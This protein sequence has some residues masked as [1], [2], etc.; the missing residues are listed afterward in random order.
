ME[1]HRARSGRTARRALGLALRATLLGALALAPSVVPEVAQADGTAD[2]ADL[3]F[4]LGN[5]A[6]RAGNFLEALE[7]YLASNRLVPNQNVVFNIARAYQRLA[8]YPE[9]YRYYAT[10]LATETD[11]EARTRITAALTELATQ[12]ALID[13]ESAPA[14]AT[15]FVDRIDLGSIGTAPLTIALPAGTYR[16]ITRLP[17]HHD[18]TSE[19]LSV[20]V[21]Q[22]SS[23]RLAL[24]RVVGTLVVRGHEGAELRVDTEDGDAACTL[25]CSLPVAPGP[26]VIHVRAA[27]HQPLA[28]AVAVTEAE[29]TRASITLVAETGSVVVRADVE[30]ALVQIDSVAVG[31]TP[32]VAAGI[33]V[34]TR[35]VRVSARGYEPEEANVE[36]TR[37]RQVE[38]TS[39]R[40]RTLHEVSAASREVETIEDAPASVSVISTA[41]LEAF[42]YPTLVEALRGQR[43]FALTSDSTY[44]NAGVRGIGQPNDY[45]SRLRVLQDGA[46][47]NENILQQAFIGYDGRVDLGDVERIEIVRGAGSVLYG[48][49]AVSGVINLVPLSHELPTSARFD[50]SLADGNVGRARGAFNVHLSDK[51]GVRGSV[52]VARSGGR[53]EVLYFDLDGDGTVDAN[54][55]DGVEQFQAVTGSVRAWAGPLVVQG[56]FTA[57]TVAIPTGTFDTIYNRLE[58]NFDDHL[59]LLEVRY[60]PRLS[61]RVELRT[62][63]YAGYN[64]FHLDFVYEGEDEASMTAFEQPYTETYRGFW[65][66]GEAR[67]VAQLHPTL[68]LSAGAEAAHHPIVTMRVSDQNLDGSRNLVLDEDRNFSTIAGYAL[69]DWEPA[70]A[71]SVSLGGRVDAW[72]LPAPSESFV[73]FNPRLAVILRPSAHDTVKL[74]AG[75]A[76][77]A[78]STY[79]QFYQDGGRTSLGSTCCGEALRPETLYAGE[80]EYTHRFDDEWSLLLSGHLQYAQDFI[81]TLPVPAAND[82]EMLGLTYSANSSTD[83]RNL[84]ADVEVRRELRDGWMFSAMLGT[85]SA[86]YLEAPLAEGATANRDVPNAPYLFGS[87]RAIFP[88]LDRLLRGALR[89]SLE[90]PRRVDLSTNDTTGWAVVADVVVTGSVDDLGI[91]YAVGVYNLFDWEYQVP[92]SAFPSPTMPQR[93]RRFMASLSLEL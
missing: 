10:A 18:A 77:R 48:T 75:R 46:T 35:H 42:R 53:D 5:E 86:R 54:R 17:G 6:Y 12:V 67:V 7:H 69:A 27:G 59:G 87:A 11:T 63:V 21:G 47:L 68:R 72:L 83:Q 92:V 3:Q 19:P 71:V 84:G 50:L 85:L 43:G 74:I 31:F 82:P 41:E 34:G 45:N 2:E 23:V 76:F 57:R 1:G 56:F 8:M 60:E 22:R 20:A 36:V 49:G 88:V 93:G 13:V 66:G 26:H 4:R 30:G 52:A 9:A 81:E 29:T 15:V 44:S 24:T 58:N 32:L 79:E 51:A 16:I 37:E 78:P 65:A 38:L 64:Y 73:S 89:L 39:L 14:G 70:Q 61:E 40:M 62:R 90:A 80:V 55:A 33:A 91:H 28:R 25:P